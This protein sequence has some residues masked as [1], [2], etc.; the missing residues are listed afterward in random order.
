MEPQQRRAVSLV[1][2]PRT[3][4]ASP[5]LVVAHTLFLDMVGYSRLP[6]PTQ[7][8]VQTALQEIVIE[9]MEVRRARRLHD[10]VCRPTGDGMALLFFED[11]QSPLRCA[12]EITAALKD[13]PHPIRLRMGIHTGPIYR[14]RD[15]NGQEDVAGDGIVMAQRVMDCGDSRHILLSRDTAT[16]LLK[17]DPW[18]KWLFDIGV[19]TVK[20]GVQVHLYSLASPEFGNTNRPSKALDQIREIQERRAANENRMRLNDLNEGRSG[21][22]RAA[23]FFLSFVAVFA[24]FSI[25]WSQVSPDTFE[26]VMGWIRHTLKNAGGGPDKKPASPGDPQIAKPPSLNVNR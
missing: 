8:A 7:A 2:L 6:P 13:C 14:V 24:V 3:V 18:R 26:D 11:M 23:T 15:L 22:K 25:S 5:D 19:C 9:T 20:H 4:A 21:T 1:D 16:A 10:I 17:V 12:L